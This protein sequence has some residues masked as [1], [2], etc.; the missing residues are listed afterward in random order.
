MHLDIFIYLSRKS[1]WCS[2]VFCY[3]FFLLLF[4]W[5]IYSYKWY[6]CILR[7]FIYTVKDW[8]FHI[9][10]RIQSIYL[11]F[12]YCIIKMQLISCY[13]SVL[14]TFFHI[15][16]M[17]SGGSYWFCT[18]HIVYRYIL[19]FKYSIDYIQ[20]EFADGKME[21]EL[22][23]LYWCSMHNPLHFPKKF[24]HLR[25][26]LKYF[27]YLTSILDIIVEVWDEIETVTI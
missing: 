8:K 4:C 20:F 22:S 9:S 23:T 26:M 21:F 7:V 19:T 6:C 12:L 24:W 16:Q 2:N 27:L 25:W 10:C 14:M 11:L 18:E 3:V 17:N 13:L 5:N 15:F 1:Q